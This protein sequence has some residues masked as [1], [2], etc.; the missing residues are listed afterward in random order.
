MQLVGGEGGEAG[1]WR[2]G[3]FVVRF[4]AALARAVGSRGTAVGGGAPLVRLL[5]RGVGSATFAASPRMTGS[6]GFH[7]LLGVGWGVVFRLTPL[8]C[9]G[10]PRRA[11]RQPQPHDPRQ[12]VV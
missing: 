5:V 6:A 10:R 1:V 3:G 4:R 12:D 11:G 2:R 9:C 8:H 7:N